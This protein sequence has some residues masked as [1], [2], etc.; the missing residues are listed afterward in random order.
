MDH[1]VRNT[2]L[3]ISSHASFTF[4]EHTFRQIDG[5]AM[6]AHH[7]PVFATGFMGKFV[8][9]FFGDLPQWLELIPFW[10]R[11]LDDI[12]GWWHGTKQQFEEFVNVLNGWS[13]ANGWAIQFEI[14]GFGKNVAFLDTEVY[15]EA[16]NW[17]TKLFYKTT[18]L[19][20][21]LNP[22]YA[23]S[24][25]TIRGIPFGVATRVRRICSDLKEYRRAA[26]LF[27]ETFFARRGLPVGYCGTGLSYIGKAASL[28][29]VGKEG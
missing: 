18:D 24:P 2:A 8:S 16:G 1:H 7:A 13:S 10:R 15:Y 28:D 17:E 4:G 21:Y 3:F 26:K 6:G 19:H 9:E 23:H 11:L 27:T 20:A 29:V 25:G 12:V 5:T 22:G 14:S